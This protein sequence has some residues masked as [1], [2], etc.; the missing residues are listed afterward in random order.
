MN[1]DIVKESNLIDYVVGLGLE[2]VKDKIKA[3]SEVKQI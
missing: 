3:E 1:R 2:V